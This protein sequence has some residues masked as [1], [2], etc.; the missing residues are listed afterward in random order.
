[1]NTIEKTQV[2]NFIGNVIA[3]EGKFGVYDHNWYDKR[4]LASGIN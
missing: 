1:M 4:E 2:E 3:S